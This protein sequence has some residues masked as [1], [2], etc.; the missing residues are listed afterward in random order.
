MALTSTLG[1]PGIEI[2]EID[3]SVRLD[4]STSTTVF[5]PGFAAQGPIEEVISIG[6]MADFELIYGKPTNAAERYFYYTVKALL[7]NGGP[8]LSVLTSRLPY[9]NTEGGITSNGYTLMA[10]PAIPV[11][12][13]KY[14]NKFIDCDSLIIDGKNTISDIFG[15]EGGGSTVVENGKQIEKDGE[16]NEKESS[17]E[18]LVTQ[19]FVN[20]FLSE[21]IDN[22][23][24]I[25]SFASGGKEGEKEK[26]PTDFN[27]D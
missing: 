2:R 21:D 14:D 22:K 20:E 26:L 23:K 13:K 5:V 3:N 15:I 16:L 11:I 24:F 8:G 17:F 1:S 18:V 9:G 12:K 27:K 19:S 25:I 6:N 7:D 4:T 10:Y